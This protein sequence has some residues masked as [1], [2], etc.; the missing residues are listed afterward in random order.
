MNELLNFVSFRKRTSR[1]IFHPSSYH[2]LESCLSEIFNHSQGT[3]IGFVISFSEGGWMIGTPHCVRRHAAF[4]RFDSVSVRSLPLIRDWNLSQGGSHGER[5]GV[6]EKGSIRVYRAKCGVVYKLEVYLF[7]ERRLP[8][9]KNQ[10]ELTVTM[11]ERLKRAE[12]Q[13]AVKR[14]FRAQET[15]NLLLSSPLRLC[16]V[17]WSLQRFKST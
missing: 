12:N 9:P 3:L 5:I 17:V 16:L 6:T 15:P 2:I 7:V 14:A 8:P 11:R 10:R 4:H 13:C 1:F